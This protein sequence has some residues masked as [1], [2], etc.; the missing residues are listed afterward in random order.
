MVL[1]CI[2]LGI[3]YNKHVMYF[4][5]IHRSFLKYFFQAFCPFFGGYLLILICLNS[6]YIQD[7]SFIR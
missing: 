6:L 3:N 1:I 4:L 5:T 7:E 2:S